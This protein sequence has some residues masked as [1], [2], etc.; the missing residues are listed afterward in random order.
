M[1]RIKAQE[2]KGKKVFLRVDLNCPVE[3]GKITGDTRIRAH[4]ETVKELSNR[5][6]RVIVLSHQG[7][8][9]HDDSISLEQHARR[10]HDHVGKDVHFVD[11]VVGEKA[12]RKISEA[13]DGDIIVLDNVRSLQCE[14]NHPDGEGKIIHELAPLADYFVLD[15]LSVAHRKHSSVVGFAKRVPSFAGDVLAHEMDAIDRVRHSKDVTF[16]FGGSKVE[17]SFTVMKKWL[18]DGRARY[19]LVGGALAVLLLHAARKHVGGSMDYLKNSG[20]DKH[21]EEAAA[22]LKTYDGKIVLPIDVGLYHNKE[23]E[24]CDVDSIKHGEIWDIG[25]KTIELYT[26]IINEST[27][28]VMNG[29]AGVYEIDAFSRGTRALLE[30]VA[31]CDAF[32][33]L[34]GGHTIT[35]IEKFGIEKKYFSYV[36]LSGKALIEYLCGKE[37]AGIKALDDN[38]KKFLNI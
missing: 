19:V 24:D 23:R 34:G 26:R 27:C 2:V 33:L 35:A 25:P 10:L 6:A 14:T 8:L 1:R 12:K 38:E 30:A 32:S 16:I 36:S 5:G 9:G 3:N 20:L 21:T 18:A 11:D 31:K 4:A 28:I 7:R 15:A 22:L 13:R 37:L 17:D 29:P